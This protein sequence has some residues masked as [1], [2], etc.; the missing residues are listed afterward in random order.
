MNEE[1][2]KENND[3]P[4]AEVEITKFAEDWFKANLTQGQAD[5]WF[6][7]LSHDFTAE[8]QWLKDGE[9][10]ESIKL[11]AHDQLAEVYEDAPSALEQQIVLRKIAIDY[12][13][14][15]ICLQEYINL[16]SKS[17]RDVVFAYV[18]EGAEAEWE[19]DNRED[20][21][22]ELWMDVIRYKIIYY[23]VVDLLREFF[24]D[25]QENY[26]PSRL[27][28]IYRDYLQTQIDLLLT[29]PDSKNQESIKSMEDFKYYLEDLLEAEK[30]L[31]ESGWDLTT[32]E[33]FYKGYSEKLVYSN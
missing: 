18:N 15:L 21:E 6:E 25:A 16:K 19:Y 30:K 32:R 28:F 5:A 14:S 8:A 2:P 4:L 11:E 3:A 7:E 23:L 27:A 29:K 22:N 20:F 10:L 17:D 1:T 31:I 9:F 33:L 13:L 26:F 12:L 24:F